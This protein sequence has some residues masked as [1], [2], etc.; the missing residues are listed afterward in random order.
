MDRKESNLKKATPQREGSGRGS[1]KDNSRFAKI[2]RGSLYEVKHWLR[3]ANK[4]KLLSEKEVNKF[5]DILKVLA[6]KLS[7]YINYLSKQK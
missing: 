3:R 4:Q 6:P 5:Q 1:S 2:A 7:A